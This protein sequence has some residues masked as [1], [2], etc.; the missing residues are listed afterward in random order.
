VK[1]LVNAAKNFGR[2]GP[3]ICKSLDDFTKF[4]NDHTGAKKGNIKSA[5]AALLLG[6]VRTAKTSLG[7]T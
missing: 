2:R 4:V 1:K 3:S 5:D 6:D 7:C